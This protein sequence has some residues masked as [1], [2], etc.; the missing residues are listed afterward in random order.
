M[1]NVQ[2]IKLIDNNLMVP[3]YGYDGMAFI[4]LVLLLNINIR[5]R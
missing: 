1:I 3:Y 4:F 2:T 5:E